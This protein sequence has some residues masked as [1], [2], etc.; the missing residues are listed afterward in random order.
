MPDPPTF[1]L[2][3][4]IL[5][6]L[7]YLVYRRR[8][9]PSISDLPG[10]Q[11][12]SFLLGTTSAAPQALVCS[13]RAPGSLPEFQQGQVGVAEFKWAA[14]YGDV[15]RVKGILG[16][17]RLFVADPKAIHH[18]HH[19]ASYNIRKQELR[20]ELSRVFTGPGLS[21]VEG[22]AHKRQRRINSPAFGT[23]DAR[24]YIPI[25]L[26]YA[27]ST[28]PAIL[29]GF[30]FDA[31][32]EVAFDYR[33][34]T[35]DNL[36]SEHPLSTALNSVLPQMYTP[37]T[38]KTIFIFGLLELL[39]AW[40]MRLYMHHAPTAGL[41]NSRRVEKIA[42]DLAREL[43]AA[44]SE[45]I[46][47]GKRKRDIMSL[48]VKANLSENPRTS[49]TEDEMLAQMQTIMQA[50]QET[51]AVT[52]SWTL[53]ELT[54]HRD[55]Q[56]KLRAEIQATERAI[57]ERGET[58][59][60]W[61]DFE[62][63]PYTIAVMKETLRYHPVAYN[64]TREAARDEVLP[65]SNPITTRSGK[66]LTELPIRK[67]QVIVVSVA[68]YNRNTQIFGA[69]AGHFNPERWLDDTV[70]PLAPLGVYGNLYL[71]FD[72]LRKWTSSMHRSTH[73]LSVFRV[74]TSHLQVTVWRRPSALYCVA[75]ESDHDRIY[76]YQS[77]LVELVK[78]FAFTMDPAT[79]QQLRRQASLVMLPMLPGKVG[80]HMPLQVAPIDAVE[81]C[82]VFKT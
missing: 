64:N 65:L 44:K 20:A 48:L 45:E 33:F 69:D 62:A 56:N 63:M 34:G 55:V 32:G 16:T 68:A 28:L 70:K 37:P 72:D 29:R 4:I 12:E 46:A 36:N 18:I 13:P 61:S 15:Y 39:P 66:I 41:R 2:P 22:E 14:Q 54:Q 30:F 21:Y 71:V 49:L 31:I 5:I 73:G 8:L 23:M 76:E 6:I 67:H 35:T 38:K 47:A 50:G 27:S 19:L 43:V 24:S 7:G 26:S 51:T 53:F 60:T 52:L 59:F 25:F 79:A 80:P 57:R 75:T 82:F 3:I 40:L 1:A 74:L 10:P 17:E 78:N 42:T 9:S 11:P 58:Q 77:F 81:Q